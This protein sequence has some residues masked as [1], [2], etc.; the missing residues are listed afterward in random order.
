MICG[1]SDEL[2]HIFGL[3]EPAFDPLIVDL[4]RL[5]EI[6]FGRRMTVFDEQPRILNKLVEDLL[7]RKIAAHSLKAARSRQHARPERLRFQNVLYRRNDRRKARL[8]LTRQHLAGQRR[9]PF[10]ISPICPLVELDL[11]LY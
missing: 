4:D 9:K 7:C 2:L 6:F 11:P 10:D 5:R 1:V 3:F 8:E